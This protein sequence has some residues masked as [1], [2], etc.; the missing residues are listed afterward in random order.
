M[1]VLLK[2][3]HMHKLCVYVCVCVERRKIKL[4]RINAPFGTKLV[5]L[6]R[7]FFLPSKETFSKVSEIFLSSYSIIGI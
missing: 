3:Q 7:V 4:N 5:L 1:Y 6:S 2:I